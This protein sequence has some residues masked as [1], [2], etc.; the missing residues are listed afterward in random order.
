MATREGTASVATTMRKYKY[1]YKYKYKVYRIHLLSC[2]CS[3]CG[4]VKNETGQPLASAREC[5]RH[6]LAQPARRD[7]RGDICGFGNH[8]LTRP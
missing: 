8:R 7:V 1:K 2:C 4:K 6:H 3:E 5:H